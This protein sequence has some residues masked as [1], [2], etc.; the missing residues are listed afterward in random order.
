MRLDVPRADIDFLFS[1]LR[2]E[3]EKFGWVDGRNIVLLEPRTAKGRNE[4]LAV[5]IVEVSSPADFERAFAAIRRDNAE[6]L[7]LPPE[8]LIRSMREAIGEFDQRL[9]GDEA[10]EP[11][12]A[13]IPPAIGRL[14]LYPR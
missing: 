6:S 8:P 14:A 13:V 4:R 10:P 2:P 1:A 3:L 7:L 11:N 5:Q 9:S 12:G